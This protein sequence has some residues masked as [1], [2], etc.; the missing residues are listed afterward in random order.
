MMIFSEDTEIARSI[1]GIFALYFASLL[2]AGKSKCMDYFIISP[3][4]ALSCSPS[5]AP[6][7]RETPSTF[8]VHQSELSDFVSY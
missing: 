3:V 8:R 5:P 4:G 6:N 7:F 1:L 2:D